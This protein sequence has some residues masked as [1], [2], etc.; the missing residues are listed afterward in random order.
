MASA[1]RT[2]WGTDTGCGGGALESLTSQVAAARQLLIDDHA[3]VLG[4]L[5]SIQNEAS[6]LRAENSELRTQLATARDNAAHDTTSK[7]EG[8]APFDETSPPA[9]PPWCPAPD[10]PGEV[11]ADV[12]QINTPAK[13]KRISPQT[14]RRR[15]PK[16]G[17]SQG[18]Q[19]EPMKGKQ[20]FG[21][22]HELKEKVRQ[23]IGKKAYNVFDFYKTDG[24]CQAIGRHPFFEYITLTVILTNAIWIAVD[25]DNNEADVIVEAEPLFQ[26]V[27][28]V[29][30]TYFFFEWAIRCMAFEKKTAGLHDSWFVFDGSLL[31]LMVIE[32]WVVSIIYIVTGGGSSL[33]PKGSSVIK[34]ARMARLL[35]MGRMLKLL[36]AVPELMTLVK[37]I[38]VACRAVACTITLLIIF[39]Y[40]A[41]I[42][43][44][45]LSAND[46][47]GEELFKNVPDTMLELLLWGAVPDNADLVLRAKEENVTVMICLIVFLLFAGLTIMNMLLGVMVDVIVVVSSV[48][49]EQ[50]EVNFVTG[51]VGKMLEES[52]FDRNKDGRI[53]RSEFVQLLD[54]S[55]AVKA[56][57]NVGVDP[58]ALVDFADIIFDDIDEDGSIS[59]GDFMSTV[60]ALR[61]KNQATVK[62]IVDVRKYMQREIASLEDRI[63]TQ[64]A[65][66]LVPPSHDDD[67]EPHLHA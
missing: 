55:D 25:A 42:A 12:V 51:Q 5:D 44:S 19:A 29:F 3:R 15:K 20:V 45:R 23:N 66:L 62:D 14:D 2:A 10:P 16:D 46:P 24:V 49:I 43:I 39:T 31:V 18:D 17:K 59:F 63:V 52:D 57:D 38:V 47:L 53:T 6:V 33:L 61:G 28:H 30:C 58:V 56:L 13:S 65:S 67:S 50:L 41:A 11:T 27:E 26:L 35:R 32:T 60:F 4:M 1:P 37:G 64:V 8:D 54:I 22:Q 7:A 21:A 36:R 34:L 48:E 40:V 9:V